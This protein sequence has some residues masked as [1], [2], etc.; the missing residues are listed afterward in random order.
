MNVVV[1]LISGE[2]TDAEAIEQLMSKLADVGYAP[3]AEYDSPCFVVRDVQGYRVHGDF[4]CLIRSE[5]PTGIAKV[6]YDIRLE[7]I[8]LHQCDEAIVFGED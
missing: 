7:A 1:A 6:A 4:P 2:L 8:A 3:L 5:L